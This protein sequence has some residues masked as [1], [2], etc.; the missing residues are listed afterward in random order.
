MFY[1]RKSE[2]NAGIITKFVGRDLIDEPSK[3]CLYGNKHRRINLN[4]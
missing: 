4:D 1:V 2:E 3:T